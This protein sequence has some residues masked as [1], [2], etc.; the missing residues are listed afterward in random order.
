M[1]HRVYCCLVSVASVHQ[2]GH[3]KMRRKRLNNLY[4]NFIFKMHKSRMSV[5]YGGSFSKQESRAVARESR[6]AAVVVFGLKFADNIHYKF[7]S[8]GSQASKARLQSSKRTGA[9]Q[10]LTQNGHSGHVFWS[11]WKGDKGLS[12]N[13][14][15]I[16]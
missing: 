12:N 2:I 4:A 8:N 9:E 13:V 16:C 14:S 7:K 11:Q 6:D 3:L 1:A 15:L 5:T 10:H